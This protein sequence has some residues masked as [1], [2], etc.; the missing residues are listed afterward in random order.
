M[1]MQ[2]KYITFPEGIPGFET[3]T[4]FHL[5]KEQGAFCLLQSI[6]QPEIGFTLL[7][8]SQLNIKYNPLIPKNYFE[9]IGDGE[10]NEYAVYVVTTIRENISDCTVN[11]AGPLLIHTEKRVGIQVIVGNEEYQVRHKL[12]DLIRGR[13]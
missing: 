4:Q 8:P 10:D 7:D 12:E 6:E 2:D 9:K 1:K 11:L 13:E 5:I 3:L